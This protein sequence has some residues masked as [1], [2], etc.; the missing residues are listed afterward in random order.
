[1]AYP[2]PAIVYDPGTGSVTLSPTLPNT[3]KPGLNDGNDDQRSGQRTRSITSS[4]IV[5][6][7]IERVD[8]LRAITFELVAISELPAWAAFFDYAI[9]GGKF[10]Y[11][12][13]ANL[14]D[15]QDWILEDES[16][17]PQRAIIGYATFTFNVRLVVGDSGT[18]STGTGGSA[19]TGTITTVSVTAPNSGDFDWPHGVPGILAA[20]PVPTSSGLLRPQDP[21][22]DGTNLHLNASASGVTGVVYVFS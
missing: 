12:P 19:G 10:S 14:S 8:I 5:Q 4:G 18:I 17:K 11:Y 2:V 20:I 7:V 13:D 9:P 16:W 3:K 22:Y 21:A 1:M 15:H 6:D